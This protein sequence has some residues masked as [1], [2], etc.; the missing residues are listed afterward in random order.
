MWGFSPPHQAVELSNA[1]RSPLHVR[2]TP[3]DS[4]SYGKLVGVNDE[5][6][7]PGD[8][9]ADET[10]ATVTGAGYDASWVGEAVFERGT[11][12]G[13]YLILD[14]LGS[15]GMGVVYAAYDP[16]LDRKVAVKIMQTKHWGTDGA[17]RV[18][19]E[20]QA[21][22]KLSHPNVAT[23]HDVGTFGDQLFIAMELI[24]GAT[25]KEWARAHKPSW[26]EIV[27]VFIK[28]GRGVAAA[29]SVGLVH[30]DIKASNIMVG[31]NG[32][33]WV[34]DF[35]VARAA[36]D[37]EASAPGADPHSDDGADGE[38]ES[39]SSTD[40]R[41][42][43]ALLTP[44][45]RAGT[46]IGT[47]AYMAPEQK[48]GI[49]S[50]RADQYSFCVALHETLFGKRPARGEPSGRVPKW[51]RSV[52]KRGL[53]S[54]P[55]QR[56]PSMTEL[57]ADLGRDPRQRR[58]RVG[59]ILGA[60][61]LVIAGASAAIV[62]DKEADRSCSGGE[63]KLTGVWDE[64]VKGR[65]RQA[66]SDSGRYHAGDSFS[67][68]AE[69]LDRRA[70][71][72]IAMRRE[73]CSATMI[74]GDQSDHLLDLRM[75]CLDRR[76]SEMAALVRV[77]AT[78]PDPAVVDRAVQA[79]LGLPSITRCDDSEA[80]TAAIPPPEDAAVR[81][82]VEELQQRLDR[83]RAL[84][85]AG[86][87]ADA[88]AL[89]KAVA[90]RSQELDYRPIQATA[91]HRVGSL[92]D[93]SGD[94]KEA[95]AVMRQ[96]MVI[97]AEAKDHTLVAEI[98][99]EL[100]FII[101]QEQARYDQALAM[102]LA[103]EAATAQAGNQPVL[104]AR[105]FNS[106]GSVYLRQGNYAEAEKHYRRALTLR[107]E[108]VGTDHHDVAMAYTN[109]AVVL[110]R[111]GKYA[112]ARP[113]FERGLAIRERTLGADHPDLA[114]FLSN[115]GSLGVS[116]RNYSDALP[117]IERSLAIREK[118]LG[119]DHP[120]LGYPLNNLGLVRRHQHD[121]DQARVHFN[122]AL[123]IWERGF[124]QDHPRVAIPLLNLGELGE[125]EGDCDRARG[126][127]QR[128]LALVEK[129]IGRD[130]P[131]AAYALLGLGRCALADGHAARALPLLERSLAIRKATKGDP[132]ELAEAR[133][134][135]ARAL[136]S[137]PRTRT[138]GLALA[139]KA[140]TAYAELG[141]ATAH[142]LAE[143]DSWLKSHQ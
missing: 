113:L 58:R 7:L 36:T 120:S 108:A 88:L 80:L 98:W 141:E 12:M 35:G 52:L 23:V 4:R 42:T 107:Q 111:Q 40:W 77:F 102:R 47:P 78:S 92:H 105:L 79:T 121:F 114:L 24:D 71:E 37:T 56:Y 45:T 138:R 87:F 15:G 91:L 43:S 81:A 51:V 135:L 67:R 39:G 21:M 143:I 82:V 53:E 3:G 13:R 142:E 66:F 59:A 48:R 96:A 64:T 94:H 85:D 57:L 49:S 122:R 9:D 100:I 65:V 54:K 11:K 133:F 109:L 95:E 1:N 28:A 128:A 10:T 18:R 117:Y 97:A 63:D 110:R 83:A 33:A 137:D 31:A 74:R 60:V 5:T 124:G 132:G 76:L 125:A 30:R 22:A 38:G 14:K 119:A 2:L 140:R 32:R 27:A 8:L 134:A 55:E 112:E 131:Y 70:L 6:S 123:E 61:A 41:R 46:V 90:E 16:D 44:M 62:L 73:A 99:T 115:L 17:T 86:K 118:A 25:V 26:R 106:L 116:Q 130:H 72:W 129:A 68:V 126:Y 84:Q 103:V 29:H 139:G 101:G 50:P 75:A 19:R 127:Y 104:Q 69:I 34:M 136:G 20:A 89:A 93:A